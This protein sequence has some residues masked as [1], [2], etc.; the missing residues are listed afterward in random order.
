MFVGRKEELVLI[1]SKLETNA[2]ELGVIYGQR[3]IGK[4]LL[5]LKV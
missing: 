2:F 5:F 1:H 4:P 3:R